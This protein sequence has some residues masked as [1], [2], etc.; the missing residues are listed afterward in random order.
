MKPFTQIIGALV[1]S[2]FLLNS[3]A[4]EPITGDYIPLNTADNGHKVYKAQQEVHLKSG[5]HFSGSANNSM[6]AYIDES[7]VLPT[8]YSSAYNDATFSNTAINTNLTVGATPGS[9]GVS[10]SGAA[11]YSIPIALPK[12]TNG[13]QPNISLTYNSQS[14]NG[15]LGYGWH[16]SG[17]SAISRAGKTHYHNNE[18]SPV[19]ITNT[20][21]YM[22]DGQYLIPI[23][24]ENGGDGTEYRTEAES[25]IRIRSQGNVGNGP[26]RWKV[27]YKNG[28][29]HYY[30]NDIDA[31]LSTNNGNTI[32]W[33]LK[34]VEDKYGNYMTY[35]CNNEGGQLRIETIRYT[36]NNLRNLEHHSEVNFFY[37]ERR[38][39]SEGYVSGNK[40]TT[41]YLLREI[42]TKT[43]GKLYRAYHFEHSYNTY[44][45]LKSVT[46][47]AA[48]GEKLNATKFKY[49]G[50]N[51]Y[52][53]AYEDGNYINDLLEA[54]Q[55]VGKS[56]YYPGDFN[57]DGLTD[58]LGMSYEF[59]DNTEHSA[60][61]TSWGVYLNKNYGT[62]E[63]FE[64]HEF[65]FP[66]LYGS[67]NG[68]F[69]PFNIE[70]HFPISDIKVLIG[71][72]NG[73]NKDDVI[74]GSKGMF[75]D[76]NEFNDKH[77]YYRA[78]KSNPQ[79]SGYS[80][81]VNNGPVISMEDNTP[82]PLSELISEIIPGINDYEK[83]HESTLI[84]YDGDGRMEFFGINA[85]K[86]DIKISSFDSRININHS[87]NLAANINIDNFQLT[88]IDYDGDRTHDILFSYTHKNLNSSVNTISYFFD[89]D[90]QDIT[91]STVFYEELLESYN[92]IL[93]NGKPVH[94]T[95]DFNGDGLQDLKLQ[96]NSEIKILLSKG[97]QNNQTF[98]FDSFQEID[99]EFDDE[100]INSEKAFFN[101]LNSDGKTDIMLMNTGAVYV[102]GNPENHL[103][104]IYLSKGVDGEFYLQESVFSNFGLD[105]PHNNYFTDLNGDG[106]LEFFVNSSM[107]TGFSSSIS[108]YKLHAYPVN[109]IKLNDVIDGLGN[110]IEFD[111]NFLTERK[112]YSMN[113]SKQFPL[114]VFSS[115]LSV[116]SEI[117]KPNGI[118]G[119]NTTNY[120]YKDAVLHKSGK[121][122]LGFQKTTLENETTGSRIESY[123]AFHPTWHVPYPTLS[124][125][126]LN[127]ELISESE[128]EYYF[129]ALGNQRYSIL[130]KTTT[131]TNH[132]QGFTTVKDFTW[133]PEGNL[134]YEK[135]N[136]HNGLEVMEGHYEYEQQGSH[137]KNV[138]ISAQVTQKRAGQDPFEVN[139]QYTY[140]S[141]GTLKEQL[142]FYGT[143]KQV[144]TALL[145]DNFGNVSHKFRAS[146]GLPIKVDRY[147]YDATARYLTEEVNPEG[148]R[149][150]RTYHLRYGTP[151]SSTDYLGK[152]TTYDYNAFGALVKTT[153]PNGE[154]LEHHTDWA[155]DNEHLFKKR[156]VLNGNTLSTTWHD[157]LGRKVKQKT[158]GRNQDVWTTTSYNDKGQVSQQSSPHFEGDNPLMTSYVYD[159][160]GR[161]QTV[162]SPVGVSTSSYSYADN[163]FK[164]TVVSPQGTVSSTK[165]ASGKVIKKED[166]GGD[167]SFT[168]YSHGQQ[169]A[170]KVNGQ[171]VASMEYDD[172]ARQSALHDAN[173]GSSSY[174]YNA[175]GQLIRQTDAKSQTTTMVYDILGRV[176]SKTSPEGLTDYSYHNN[177]YGKGQ[178]K[179]VTAPNG[180]EE[181]YGY[182]SWGR[183]SQLTEHIDGTDYTTKYDYNNKHQLTK[184]TYPTGFFVSN[185]YDNRGYLKDVKANG[186]QWI[187]T[188]Q[189]QNAMGQYTSYRYANGMQVDKSYNAVGMPTNYSCEGIQNMSFDFD[190]YT[191]NLMSRTDHL[192]GLHETFEYDDLDRL[193]QHIR[194]NTS[195]SMDVS[196]ADL[197]E[198]YSYFDNGNIKRKT[199]VSAQD[200]QYHPTKPHAL[201]GVNDV[202]NPV[203]SL[204]EQTISYNSAQDPISI[205]ENSY[206]LNFEY[207]PHNNRVRSVLSHN[208]QVQQIKTY[209]S[210]MEILQVGD[211]TTHIHY[212]Q[213]GD[214]LAAFYVQKEG[215]EGSYYFAFKDYL[216]S[217]LTL[218]DK[219]GNVVQEQSFD[220]W[221]RYRNTEDWSYE[222]VSPP[223]LADGD[224]TWL[225]GYTGHEYLPQF[226]LIHMNGRLY[227]PYLGRMLS[228]D[229]L[230]HTDFGTQGYNR[231]S[232]AANNPLKYTD[233]SGEIVW[234]PIIAFAIWNG[235]LNLAVNMQNVNNFGDG[236]GYFVIGAAAG[237]VGGIAGQAAAAST[238]FASGALIGG[239]GSFG[240]SLIQGA[241]SAAL[242]GSDYNIKWALIA[243]GIGAI[244][245]GLAGHTN[246]RLEELEYENL[247]AYEFN[248]DNKSG[249][250]KKISNLGGANVNFYNIGESVDDGSAFRHIMTQ[251]IEGANAINSFRIW[252]SKVSTISAFSIPA[253][254]L[255]GYFLEPAGPS[256]TTPNQNKRIPAGQYEIKTHWRELYGGKYS[257]NNS[258]L[259]G[260]RGGILI[261]AGYNSSNT[262]GCL[263]PGCGW[264]GGNELIKPYPHLTSTHKLNQI[265]KAIFNGDVQKIN[266]INTF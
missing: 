237:A 198:G 179:K 82:S 253:S 200:Y 140:Y 162:N 27:E 266:I 69:R 227:D 260:S 249:D 158:Q 193:S 170:V 110:R 180:N 79:V 265:N 135:T 41:K 192:K 145:Y 97:K 78:Y 15:I 217:I 102:Q 99:F 74:L 70:N 54:N 133:S 205:S 138:R 117:S 24:G 216:G 165:D 127:G 235:A 65:L 250:I 88:A 169:K 210:N 251:V 182:D 16:I 233:P 56:I 48:F 92:H 18:V 33:H 40:L 238:T 242:N 111:Y 231:Y 222:D 254:G 167:V 184:T 245:G 131:A 187:F 137:T 136:V 259:L 126:Y 71:D 125:S 9:A 67:L 146:V 17:L 147:N 183:L 219:N 25:Y 58:L 26:F 160:F 156:E 241:G 191:A 168:Y 121:G 151:V 201:V 22:L 264:S 252:Q 263:L 60:R 75:D 141:K 2:L 206:T 28:I 77:F 218:A 115:P 84:D 194:P 30:G 98:S 72:L 173:A 66:Y 132:L 208:E 215:Q 3:Q 164:T 211:T 120:S 134:T 154:V 36:A 199:D 188:A 175:Y 223:T 43:N 159:D 63:G 262:K 8:N 6:H 257:L 244:T 226:S 73:D 23:S 7:L 113:A 203:A 114:N 139:T 174:E 232:Y 240:S 81:L 130:P 176:L 59:K 239:V 29:T 12:G 124:K 94:N 45:Y 207:G 190:I 161:V 178:L 189:D 107:G 185:R 106:S 228:P 224:F 256:T 44:S 76:D 212:I 96:T 149:I 1:F 64:Y 213:G 14:G 123:N 229:N 163:H 171:V 195:E 80:T 49:E 220:A 50:L 32:R 21:R 177:G 255:T 230:V 148:D 248:V 31:R 34:K 52:Y 172:Y 144:K 4:Q 122:F 152:T 20:D 53:Q 61:F 95:L 5:Y 166:Q 143:P 68:Q 142:D 47:Q 86:R 258:D 112:N 204:Q 153:M 186:N 119:V 100:V 157:V 108:T 243:G 202:I 51:N 181:R 87:F 128:T 37:S 39:K 35:H 19:S 83:K 234:A 214:G 197:A 57:G 91:Q 11:T 13:M 93:E 247:L 118:G 155:N 116:V 55:S 109:S 209:L 225:R 90:N 105:Y 196:L 10:P 46:E 103:V 150:R 104:K 85:F 236:L 129:N 89:L 246:A 261:H 221:G 38:D 101:D 62:S 42:Q